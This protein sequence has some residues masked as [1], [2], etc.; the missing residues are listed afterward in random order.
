[1]TGPGIGNGEAISVVTMEQENDEARLGYSISKQFD[2][3]LVF[4]INLK[5]IVGKF[6]VASSFCLLN[7]NETRLCK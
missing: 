6:S 7:L 4:L 1:M 3:Q 5:S 2:P